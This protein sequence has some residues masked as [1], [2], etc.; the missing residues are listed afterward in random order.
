MNSI[1]S[2]KGASLY[3]KIICFAC[4]KMLIL[5]VKS[6]LYPQHCLVFTHFP[7]KPHFHTEEPLVFPRYHGGGGGKILDWAQSIL[8]DGKFTQS[9]TG[10]RFS[11]RLLC[12]ASD[13]HSSRENVR[14]DTQQF[15]RNTRKLFIRFNDSDIAN[16][17]N[18][19]TSYDYVTC[20]MKGIDFFCA[21]KYYTHTF[22][23]SCTEIYNILRFFWDHHLT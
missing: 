7:R 9:E 15:K 11:L 23:V 17:R 1:K 20:R 18:T 5:L 8:I 10:L 13:G 3:C 21:I 14:S 4:F 22:Y 12:F 16:L 6:T 2:P 19:K